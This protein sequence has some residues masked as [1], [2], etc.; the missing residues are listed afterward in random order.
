V[1]LFF[2]GGTVSGEELTGFGAGLPVAVIDGIAQEYANDLALEGIFTISDLGNV[3]PLIP[4]S[5]IP[6]VRLRGFR[7]KAR[8]VME[9]R[10]P[11]TPYMALA[12]RSVSAVL[13]ERPEALAESLDGTEVSAGEIARLQDHLSLFQVAMDDTLLQQTHPGRPSRFL[14]PAG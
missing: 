10:V 12:H 6:P 3:D 13:A 7:A 5:G 2:S 1:R 4:I 8:L 14:T 11:A 9:A